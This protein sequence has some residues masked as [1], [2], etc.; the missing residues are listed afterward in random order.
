M[1]TDFS[2]KKFI[3]FSLII[4]F[5]MIPIHELGHVIFQFISGNP[6]WMT[7]AE[8]IP[9]TGYVD[10]PL[11]TLGGPLFSVLLAFLSVFFLY[12]KKYTE[13]FI[14]IALIGSIGRF[15]LY[16]LGAGGDE[17]ILEQYLNWPKNTIVFIF[18][19]LGLLIF[20]LSIY[21]ISKIFESKKQRFIVCFIP[22]PLYFI[23][24]IFGLFVIEP[25]LQNL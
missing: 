16:L 14:P 23:L 9:L 1:N 25:V 22:F 12:K 15:P 4:G 6:A 17:G 11:G 7:Y 10:T 18:V 3:G 8:E 20:I 5:F 24:G 21:F 13:F 2:M 19:G